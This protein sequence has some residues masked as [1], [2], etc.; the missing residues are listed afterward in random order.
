M[1]L[2]NP[3]FPLLL[4]CRLIWWQKQRGYEEAGA[5]RVLLSVPH[6]PVCI[7][8]TDPRE[9]VSLWSAPSSQGQCWLLAPQ[10][11]ISNQCLAYCGL[12]PSFSI[13]QELESYLLPDAGFAFVQQNKTLVGE[14]QHPRRPGLQMYARCLERV[15]HCS[16]K[17]SGSNG[18]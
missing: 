5:R 7:L 11:S 9:A 12:G 3:G 10:F 4:P 1:P 6:M 2:S 17:G 13:I 16:G 8:V 18:I 15:G 14:I